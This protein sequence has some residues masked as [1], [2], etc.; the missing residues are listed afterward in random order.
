MDKQLNP[1]N[2]KNESLN[3]N[4]DYSLLKTQIGDTVIYGFKV[5]TQNSTEE[6]KDFTDCLKNAEEVFDMLLEKQ[7]LPLNLIN[8]L[9]ELVI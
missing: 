3:I 6:Y 7:V 2:I 4:A 1:I 5:S 9:D 8:V